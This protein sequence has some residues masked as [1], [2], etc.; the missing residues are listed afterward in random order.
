MEVALPPVSDFYLQA[1]NSLKFFEPLGVQKTIELDA[2]QLERQSALY[3]LERADFQLDHIFSYS[4]PIRLEQRTEIER[5]LLADLF[6]KQSPKSPN[7]FESQLHSSSFS[8]TP[9]FSIK[10]GHIDLRTVTT[11]TFVEV[12]QPRSVKDSAVSN[13]RGNFAK[14]SYQTLKKLGLERLAIFHPRSARDD[15]DLTSPTVAPQ[16]DPRSPPPPPLTSEARFQSS[17]NMQIGLGLPSRVIRRRLLRMQETSSQGSINNAVRHQSRGSSQEECQNPSL[18]VTHPSMVSFS[19]VQS[20]Q[21]SNQ[22]LKPSHFPE[23]PLYDIVEVPT[24][25]SS[26]FSFSPRGT[27]S[28]RNQWSSPFVR[29][30]PPQKK[31]SSRFQASTP[32]TDSPSSIHSEREVGTTDVVVLSP[33]A[34]VVVTSPEVSVTPAASVRPGF[35]QF[36]SKFT[37]GLFKHSRSLKISDPALSSSSSSSPVLIVH[38]DAPTGLGLLQDDHGVLCDTKENGF[39]SSI[40]VHNLQLLF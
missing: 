12:E 30:N 11:N 20:V 15:L 28:P 19:R 16:N 23:R 4:P 10:Q 24:P 22:F 17:K 2:S 33:P 21:V 5:Q 26:T 27:V 36:I 8:T 13:K 3:N 6:K 9:P 35:K 31:R 39:T 25:P 18:I 40:S 14:R 32:S 37:R 34:D 29:L 7:S 1:Q 38:A